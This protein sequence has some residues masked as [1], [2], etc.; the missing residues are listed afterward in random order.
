MNTKTFF[1]V[2]AV[3]VTVSLLHPAIVQAAYPEADNTKVNERDRMVSELTAD[4]QGQSPAD[5][6]T[7]QAIRQ[8][9]MEDKSL[10]MNAHNVK[11]ITKDG[12]VTLK[13]PVATEQEKNVILEI[14]ARIVGVDKI[15]NTLDVVTDTDP[16]NQ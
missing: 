4:D 15:D 12:R 11:I 1:A 10:S 13:G 16:I 3:A 9:V 2:I 5:V 6:Q 7:T 8:G 14:A